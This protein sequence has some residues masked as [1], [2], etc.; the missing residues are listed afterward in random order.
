MLGVK[1]K[2]VKTKN[3]Y[4]LEAFYEIVKKLTYEAGEPS[5]TKHGFSYIITWPALDRN[6]QVWLMSLQGKESCKWQI[7]KNDEAGVDNLA[8]N[9][10]ID[11]VTKGW[12][13]IGGMVGK[14]NKLCE[15]YVVDIAEA[16]QKYVDENNI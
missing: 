7:S 16:L 1:I 15:K 8:K 12:G 6:N 11:A 5:I 13:N 2:T 4:T 9:M 14:N 10:A 3:K